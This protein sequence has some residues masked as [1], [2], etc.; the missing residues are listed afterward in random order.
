MPFEIF[1]AHHNVTLSQ[2]ASLSRMNLRSPYTDAILA[3]S[4]VPSYT[5][6]TQTQ[7]Q[8]Q[9]QWRLTNTPCRVTHE[10]P[11]PWPC[12]CPWPCSCIH[13]HVTATVT[14]S[15]WRCCR[16]LACIAATGRRALLL[17]DGHATGRRTGTDSVCRRLS[18]GSAP[19]SSTG[20]STAVYQCR[21]YHGWYRVWGQHGICIIDLVLL[22]YFADIMNPFLRDVSKLIHR[23]WT[24]SLFR[25]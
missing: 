5:S 9:R 6:Q 16:S 23:L 3:D 14:V 12:Q 13:T 11:Y 10:W 15:D 4:D 20:I 7:W 24:D 22:L 1:T 19:G 2:V 18:S 21:V 17:A 25:Y 8:C